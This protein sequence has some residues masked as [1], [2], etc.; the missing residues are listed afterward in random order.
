MASIHFLT[1]CIYLCANKFAQA[2]LIEAP[3]SNSPSLP[4]YPAIFIVGDSVMDIGN[5]KYIPTWLQSNYLP[6]GQNFKTNLA[7][8]RFSNGQLLS[9]MLA[10]YLGI[11]ESLP[12]FLDPTLSK[13]DLITGVNFASAGSGFDDLT[14][15][16][17][18]AIPISQQMQNFKLHILGMKALV[19]A[20]KAMTI[21]NSSFVVLSAG[22][23]DWFFNYYDVPTRRLQ[24]D[25]DGYTNF[26]LNRVK[27]FINELYKIGCRSIM[28]SGL[29][30]TGCFP[31][32]RNLRWANHCVEDQNKDSIRYNQKLVNMLSELQRTLPGIKLVYNDFY[33]PV[34]DMLRNPS[35]YGLVDTTKGCCVTIL[36]VCNRFDI[37]TCKNPDQYL[38]WDG[39]H[40]TLAAY[41]HIFTYMKKNVLPQLSE[42][43]S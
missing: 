35:N 27:N 38:F 8:G 12:P 14:S 2:H 23:N 33:T 10:S 29:A 11:K 17:S 26:L 31:F 40:P 15:S 39:V 20:E 18:K 13:D 4:K 22:S 16:I 5:N 32:Q 41:N 34:D 21:I 42:S 25:A 28:V 37:G 43:Q 30:P 7:T 24:Y 3:V 19:G 1:I 6:Y 36:S 9:D